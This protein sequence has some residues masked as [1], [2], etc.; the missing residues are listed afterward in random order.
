MALWQEHIDSN[1]T[2]WRLLQCSSRSTSEAETRYSAT[3]IELL[4][5]VWA[6]KKASLFL[7]GNDFEVVVDHRPLI[8]IL[9]S[10]TLGELSSPRIIRLKEKLAPYNLTAVWRAGVSHKTV[11]CLSRH[12]VDSPEDADLHGESELDNCLRVFKQIANLDIDTGRDL[13]M[14]QHLDRIL[15]A[16]NSDLEYTKLRTMI[17]EGFPV[18]KRDLDPELHPYWESRADLAI[19]SDG[20]I[21]RN[22]RLLVPRPLRR[23][24]LKD[25][26]SSHQGQSR[27][28]QRARQVV[29][30]PNM[31]NDIKNMVR[32]CD[33]C[34]SFLPS[35]Q[36]E[37]LHSHDI[38]VRPFQH[39]SADIFNASG[40]DFLVLVDHFSGWPSVAKLHNSTSTT[41]V[42]R[43]LKRWITDYGAPVKLV[44]D[45]GPQFRS[46]EFQHF[47]KEWYIT[48]VT[49][50]PYN[51]Q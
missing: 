40:C 24:V 3:E 48:H 1:G 23:E 45:N 4:A 32:S 19:D 8:P 26:H 35:Q 7:F 21:L 9:N 12:P 29:F 27:T 43:Q 6:C 34:A 25:L 14:D 28:L 18:V 5:V 2:S 42:L 33:T 11:D 50:S 41:N 49:S 22:G 16:G 44:T 20:T 17:G 15:S 47:C 46:A 39:V 38:P 30:W 31:S 13:V 36:Q 10:K 37:P 51:P